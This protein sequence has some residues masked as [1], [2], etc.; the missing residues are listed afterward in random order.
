MAKSK[1]QSKPSKE[2]SVS[3]TDTL[4]APAAARKPRKRAVDEEPGPE[5]PVGASSNKKARKG[6]DRALGADKADVL[7]TVTERTNVEDDDGKNN[8]TEGVEGEKIVSKELVGGTEEV[9]QSK[10][11]NAKAKPKKNAPAATGMPVPETVTK[12]AKGTKRKAGEAGDDTVV[13]E[14]ASTVSDVATKKPKKARASMTE[15][16]N[17]TVTSFLNTVGE[18]LNGKSI[19]D[20]VTAVAEDVVNEKAAKQKAPTQRSA[21]K[22]KGK[23]KKQPEPEVTEAEPHANNEQ[24]GEDEWEPDDQ[25]AGLIQGFD[26]DDEEKESGDE[27]FKEGRSLPK[28][29]SKRGLNNKL[30]EANAKLLSQ[31]ESGVIYVGY[32]LLL[33]FIFSPTQ[34]S[35][36]P[37]YS[38][39]L[40]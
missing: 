40:L 8:A 33:H 18:A 15:S 29:P 22:G 3:P 24:D 6:L 26:S 19:A 37:L 17:E 32:D 2:D 20:D 36:N 35:Q 4:K 30:K 10:K 14:E 7:A 25:T 23:A 34:N 1:S 11:S 28:L 31:E 13:V 12:A 9:A 5:K 16:L 21:V 27:G 39:S 38:Q